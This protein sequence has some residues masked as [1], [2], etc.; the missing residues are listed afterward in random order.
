MRRSLLPFFRFGPWIPAASIGDAESAS[1]GSAPAAPKDAHDARAQSLG[2]LDRLRSSKWLVICAVILLLTIHAGMLAYSATR[3]SPTMNE[4]GHLV[5]GLSHWKFGRFEVYR[6]NPPLVHY[7]AAIP[8]ILAGYNEDWSGFYDSPG[9]R[10]EFKMGEDFIKA[11]GERSIWLFT[12]A[13][14][15]CIPFSLIGGLFCFFWSRELWSSSL[16]GL[17]TLTLWCFEPNILAHGELITTDCA[18][19]SFGVGAAYFFWR[20]LKQPTW[21]RTF[22]AGLLLG[23]AQVTKT[24]WIILFAL[25]P[26]LWLYWVA[27]GWRRPSEDRQTSSNPREAIRQL[28]QLTGILLLGLYVLNLG[29]GFDGT[30]T[31]LKDYTFVSKAFTGLKDAGDPG[32][33]FAES[34]LGELPVPVPRQYLRGIDLQKKDFESFGQPSYLRGEW[35]QGGWWY[36]YIYGLAVKTPHGSQAMLILA[37]ITV[38]NSWRKKRHS[39]NSPQPGAWEGSGVRL[40]DLVVLLATA[41]VVLILVSSQLEF[42]H[43]VRYVLPVLAF[44][45]IFI[46]GTASWLR[47]RLSVKT[48][49]HT[50]SHQWTLDCSGLKRQTPLSNRTMSS[51]STEAAQVIRR[52]VGERAVLLG[53]RILIAISLLATMAS[54]FRTYPHQLA[55]FNEV[56]GGPQNGYKHLLH[57]NLDWGQDLLL[58]KQWLQKN[59]VT[60]SETG[61]VS[62]FPYPASELVRQSGG[63]EIA[64]VVSANTKMQQPGRWPCPELEQRNGGRIG[65][66]L[67]YYLGP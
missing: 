2:F 41:V 7:V 24:T 44:T 38:L 34:W 39:S 27:S 14:W 21:E 25:W 1:E 15:G 65:F 40:R 23:L 43:H 64:T 60:L 18:A 63:E 55:Y 42:N 36:Y 49:Q 30:F 53:C 46:G 8:V 62:Y 29:Y 3:H 9:A 28:S 10:P 19:T 31:E 59:S 20:W 11:N 12:I 61:F 13:R 47:T 33:R 22:V 37:I 51:S 56:A 66:T 16:A 67:W 26:L 52:L 57:S 50:N 35:K 32:N 48:E 4:P 17:I 45:F 58:A 6:V 54:T 5:A